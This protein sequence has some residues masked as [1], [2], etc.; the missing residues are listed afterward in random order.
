MPQV[1]R[2]KPRT[3]AIEFMPYEDFHDLPRLERNVIVL[4]TNG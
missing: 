3:V 1:D 2:Y 4:V